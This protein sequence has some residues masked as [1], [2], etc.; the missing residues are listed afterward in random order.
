[1][2]C[3]YLEVVHFQKQSGANSMLNEIIQMFI[4]ILDYFYNLAPIGAFFD[5]FEDISGYFV[6]YRLAT[7]EIFEGLYFIV[8]KNLIMLLIDWFL[9]FL[10]FKVVFA[11]V[12][13]VAQFIP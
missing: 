5:M 13:L 4:N 9:I 11:I 3:L 2:K 12:N 8:G 10:M 1:M 7:A 6:T